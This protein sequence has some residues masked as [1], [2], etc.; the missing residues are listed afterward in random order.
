MISNV[1]ITNY[2]TIFLQIIDVVNFYWISSK[3]TTNINFLHVNNHL[4]HQSFVK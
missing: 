3:L 4:S 1:T 2:F